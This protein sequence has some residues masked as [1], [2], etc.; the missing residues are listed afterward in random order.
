MPGLETI[1]LDRDG[2]INRK[3]PE[4]QYV[5]CWAEWEFL[6]N[7]VEA[8][9]LLKAR[10]LRLILVTN[11][12]GVARGLMTAA[13]LDILHA[14][15]QAALGASAALDAIYACP[16]DH[17][18][19]D[20]RKP[21]SGLLLRA[22]RDDPAIDFARAAIIGDALS[23]LEAGARVGCRTFLVT[24]RLAPLVAAARARNIPIDGSGSSL[25]DIVIHQ[26]LSRHEP[27][28]REVA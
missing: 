21:Q 16:H 4:G 3:C 27:V 5:T 1:F 15:L 2:V 18:S 23:D 8:L 24:D 19:C 17:N 6:P 11:Q 9:R 13:D 25:H 20:C 28:P 22:Q 26:V 7:A 10:G 14:R 12:R